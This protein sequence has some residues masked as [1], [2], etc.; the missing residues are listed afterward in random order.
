MLTR[1]TMLVMAVVAIVATPVSADVYQ[2]LRG[3]FLVETRYFVDDPI[4]P[5]QQFTGGTASIAFAPEWFVEWDDGNQRIVASLFGRYDGDDPQR[6]H[7]DIRE[8]YYERVSRVVEFRAGLRK[9]F[10]GVAETQHLAD[11]LNQT[12]LVESFDGEDK[13]GQP[14]VDVSLVSD[15]GVLKLFAM[16]YF[17]ERTFPGR[18][19]RL[20]PP[21]R[22]DTDNPIYE[23]SD[24]ETH[25]DWAA[26]YSHY[27]SI[28]DIG[29]A[30][31]SG[32]SRDP[33]FVPIAGGEVLPEPGPLIDVAAPEALR[34]YYP[35]IDRTSI[36]VQA[37]TGSA[38]WKLEVVS[39]EVQDQ[40]YT[41]AVGGL[42]YTFFTIL[43][44]GA[45]LGVLVEYHADDR[46]DFRA[47]GF[48][49]DVFVGARLALNDSQDTALLGGVIED[50]D[51]SSRLSFVEASRRINNNLKAELEYRGFHDID[52]RDALAGFAQDSYVQ[53]GLGFYF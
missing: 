45:D 43:G 14:M 44:S 52:Q 51:V 37:T 48:Q 3:S 47:V 8:L 50:L 19:G 53:F 46:D 18:R 12:D 35:L 29:V 9:V 31:F 7:A 30:H 40:R 5:S 41:A 26:R 16:P 6:T 23:S 22:V 38:L 34:P 10:W 36:D 21:L 33:G 11:F 32:T 1:L 4:D 24:E 49:N 17:R 20:R 13:L 15:F 2:E 42:E 27:F 39:A 25:F 28:F